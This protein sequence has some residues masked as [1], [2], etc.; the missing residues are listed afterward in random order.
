MKYIEFV[1]DRLLMELGHP[2]LFHSS[3]PFDWMDSWLKC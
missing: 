3:N 2:K 1:A